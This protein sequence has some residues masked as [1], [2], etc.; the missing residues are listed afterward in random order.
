MQIN[1]SNDGIYCMIKIDGDLDASSSIILDNVLKDTVS[2]NERKILV[3]CTSLHYIS[4]AGLGV[5][6]SYLQEFENNRT[7]LILFG[8][9]DKIKDVF[10]ILGLDQL[11]TLA[12]SKEDA[13][14]LVNEPLL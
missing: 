11:L 2:N 8:V 10:Q 5:F 6:M 7:Q 1:V 14:L 13:K 9:S 3:D 12:T 4:S